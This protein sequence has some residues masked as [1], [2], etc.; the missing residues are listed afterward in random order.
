MERLEPNTSL[1]FVVDVQEHLVAAIPPDAAARV[2]H[3]TAVLLE[4]A[5]LLGVSVMASEQYP[6]GLGPTVEALRGPLDQVK[7]PRFEKLAFSAL[8]EP[9]ISAAIVDAAPRDVLLVGMEAHICVFQTARDLVKRGIRTQ[10]VADAVA[11]RTEERR[12]IGLSLSERAGAVVTTTETVLFEW[13]GRAGT[14]AFR[15]ISKMLR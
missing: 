5:R 11:S 7:A 4:A 15:A 3:N 1:V 10:V 12:A 8:G 2:V 9:P 13:L 6:K 14:D